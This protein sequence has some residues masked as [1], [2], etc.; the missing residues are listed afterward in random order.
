MFIK[1][2]QF[3]WCFL[4]PDQL[5]IF[6]LFK[7]DKFMNDKLRIAICEDDQTQLDYMETLVERWAG[8]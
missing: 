8:E 4:V 3:I 7:K 1:K 5:D 6:E 2:R